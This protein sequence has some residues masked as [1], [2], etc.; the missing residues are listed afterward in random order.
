VTAHRGSSLRAPENT[1]SAIEPAIA[2]GADFIEI[3]VRQTADGALVLLHDRDLRR[4]A[5]DRR[6]IWDVTLDEARALDVGGW[7]GPEFVGERIP[8]LAE[9]V[10][11]AR[12][13]AQLYL[14]IKPSPQT[15]DLARAVVELLEALEFL[16]DTIVASLDRNT[17]RDVAAL[18]PD[19]RTS[20][21]VHTVIGEIDRTDLHALGLRM[22]LVTPAEVMAARRHGHELHVWT[23][24]RPAQMSRF[25]DLGVDSIITDR[26]EV[27]AAILDERARVSQPQM[28]LNKIRNWL[29]Q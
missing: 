22:A 9:A 16:D 17:I 21:L 4:V 12:G 24:N 23:V 28:L 3:D 10:E 19:V 15:P 29:W 11:A 5:G 25:I 27:L 18:A 13:R 14:E 1:L 7:F 2:D 6:A 8:T 26:P 20:L